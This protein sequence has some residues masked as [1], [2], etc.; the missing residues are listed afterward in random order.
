[1]ADTLADSDTIEDVKMPLLDHLIE[2]RQRLL[3]SALSIIILFLFFY[4]F[5]EN[6]YEF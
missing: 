6:I 3:W 4:Y 1:M 2:L 5:S